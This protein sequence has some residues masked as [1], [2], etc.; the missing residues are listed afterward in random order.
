MSEEFLRVARQEVDE[1]IAE[2]GILLNECHS[3][4]D[5][6]KKTS[7]IEKHIHKIKGLA[8]MM[9]QDKIGDV[10]TRLDKILKVMLA[11]K[12][13]SGIY[14][15]LVESHSFMKDALDGK[16]ENYEVLVSEIQKNHKDLL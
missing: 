14:Q 10:A 1:D 11:G 6:L 7:D 3:D 16:S 15:T 12:A 5:V 8:P 9:G 4:E 2:I 13:V